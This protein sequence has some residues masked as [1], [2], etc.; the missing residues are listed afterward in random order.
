M[1]KGYANLALSIVGQAKEDLIRALIVFSKDNHNM[2]AYGRIAE[3]ETFVRGQWFIDLCDWDCER[4]LR[5]CRLEA[6]RCIRE[7]EHPI[8]FRHAGRQVGRGKYDKLATD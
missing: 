2:K 8:S 3:I 1:T 4:F 6:V 7:Q 5:M